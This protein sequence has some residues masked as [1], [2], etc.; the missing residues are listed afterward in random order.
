MEFSRQE[1]WSGYPR[2]SPGDTHSEPSGEP[3][4]A[5]VGSHFLLKRIL[6]TQG[7]NPGLPHCGQILYYLE[8]PRKPLD[9]ERSP[10]FMNWET[11]TE[12]WK[13]T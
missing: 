12:A 2:P 7:L 4:N 1:Y 11:M 5:G 13:S 3:K 8:P 6:L 10:Y 9:L